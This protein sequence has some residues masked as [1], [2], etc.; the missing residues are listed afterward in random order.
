MLSAF[1]SFIL[2]GMRDQFSRLLE[3][4]GLVPSTNTGGAVNYFSENMELVKVSRAN[5]SPNLRKFYANYK[6]TLLTHSSCSIKT[7]KH[8]N[9]AVVEP[10]VFHVALP[11]RWLSILTIAIITQRSFRQPTIMGHEKIEFFLHCVQTLYVRCIP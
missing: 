8:I 11:G 9:N 6:M 3:D 10:I 2:V 1:C 5:H 4:S 7:D